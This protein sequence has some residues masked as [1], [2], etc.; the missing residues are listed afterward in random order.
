[1]IEES[2]ML[3]EFFPEEEQS[4]HGPSSG[5]KIMN[6]SAFVPDAKRR[7]P[8][9][10]RRDACHGIGISRAH[11]A[12][13]LHEAGRRIRLLPKVAEGNLLQVVQ[14]LVILVGKNHFRIRG[15]RSTA[16]RSLHDAQ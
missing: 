2:S 12:A 8:E 9:A 13:I 10:R 5:L 1:M 11:V 16:G 4:V 6:E 7:Q 14:K 3:R 15:R